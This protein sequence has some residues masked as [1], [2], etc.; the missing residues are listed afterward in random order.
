[1]MLPVGTFRAADVPVASQAFW[2]LSAI[3]GWCFIVACL[4]F[5]A[6]R[7]S[8]P[9][10][11]LRWLA[12]SAFPVYFLHQAGVVAAALVVI[13]LPLGIATKLFAT[14]AL[15]VALTLPVY[16]WIVRPVPALRVLLGMKPAVRRAPAAVA[17]LA[18]PERSA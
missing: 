1:A 17:P 10:P 11:R 18:R 16:Q 12:E 6:R 14:I 4:G 9:G 5:A 7:L 3:T 8:A 15:A 2:T 13:E